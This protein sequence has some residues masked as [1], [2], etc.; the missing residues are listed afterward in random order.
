M[1]LS[2]HLNLNFLPLSL[3]SSQRAITSIL[4]T[5]AQHHIQPDQLVLEILEKEL[6][7]DFER[8]REAV[9]RHRGTG[10][11]FAIDDFGAGYA[12]LNLL[13]DFQ[14]EFIKLDMHL[15]RDIDSNGPRQA[16][17]RGILR[18]SLDLGI[19]V[20][21][22]GVESTDE[23]EW[24]RSEGIEL[25]QGWLFARPGFEQLPQSFQLP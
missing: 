10:L 8:F 19:D 13:A 4:A 5:A 15:V 24:L 21:A 16:I 22:E 11:T 14:P 6:I 9:N 1:G 20:I 17:V 3:E 12:G 18:T 23:Y 7:G 2:T 25:F